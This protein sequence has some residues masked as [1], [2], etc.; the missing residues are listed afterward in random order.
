MTGPIFIVGNSRS[1]TTMMMRIMNKHSMVHSINEP[2]FFGTL[3]SPEDDNRT[4]SKE[5]AEKLFLKLFT[6]QRAGFFEKVEVHRAAYQAEV[7]SILNTWPDDKPLNRT[8]VYNHFL[9]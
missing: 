9:F 4:L 5:E 8:A 2:H 3:W 6:R 1:G 7:D